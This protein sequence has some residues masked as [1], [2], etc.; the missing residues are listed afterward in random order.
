MRGTNE[1]S[2]LLFDEKP[3][4][5][6]PTLA[7]IIGLA[8]A[9]ILQQIHYWLLKTKHILDGRCWMF[10]SYQKWTKQFPFFTPRQIQYAIKNLEK[11]KLLITGNYNKLG[12]DRTKWYSIDY[13]VLEEICPFNKIVQSLDEIVQ[14][15]DTHVQ[16]LPETTPETTPEINTNTKEFLF[17]KF[18]DQYDKKINRAKVKKEFLRLSEPE[19]NLIFDHLPCYIESTPD[20]QYRK[21]PLTYLNNQSWKDE[22]IKESKNVSINSNL[23]FRQQN[24]NKNFPVVS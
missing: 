17:D 7:G 23:K 24:S 4:V 22:I 10:N 9:I 11:K 19:I 14:T 21:N 2:K 8:E 5:I 20:K 13:A 6:S 18:W 3:L 16:P 1:V 12:M 15:F